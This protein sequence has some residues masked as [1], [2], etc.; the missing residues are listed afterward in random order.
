MPYRDITDQRIDVD[1]ESE[2][3]YWAERWRVPVFEIR[4]AVDRA[5]PRVSDVQKCLKSF[6]LAS[7]AGG[8]VSKGEP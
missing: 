4:R 5:G 8:P 6:R 3:H 7:R 1:R 2:L